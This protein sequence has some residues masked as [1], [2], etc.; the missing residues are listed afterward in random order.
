[1]QGEGGGGV[2]EEERERELGKWVRER[3]GGGQ[4][5]KPLGREG[6]GQSKMETKQLNRR[7]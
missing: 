4:K 3:R 1:M 2:A 5:R 6:V 7:C